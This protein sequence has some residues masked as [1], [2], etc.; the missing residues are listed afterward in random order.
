MPVLGRRHGVAHVGR[1]VDV[2]H[3]V[4]LDDV[5][6]LDGWPAGASEKKRRE[7]T[8][9]QGAPMSERSQ[10]MWNN[11][12]STPPRSSPSARYYTPLEYALDRLA[13]D[14]AA[15]LDELAVVLHQL[16]QRALGAA[17]WR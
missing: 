9:Q 2:V 6:H 10:S 1:Q 16:V 11:V 8:G 12:P 7:E 5:C 17:L 4:C 3:A 15:A 14:A 13:S